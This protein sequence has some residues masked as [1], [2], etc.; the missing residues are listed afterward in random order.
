MKKLFYILIGLVL[1]PVALNA[2]GTLS[3]KQIYDNLT[4]NYYTKTA[5]D[6]KYATS[7]DVSGKADKTYVDANFATTAENALKQNISDMVDYYT[8]T[9]ADLLLSDKADTDSV[10]TKTAA[11]LL[12]AAKANSA[13]VYTTDEVN[14]L[15]NAKLDAATITNY[16]LKTETYNTGEIAL[17]LAA[18]ADA[19]DVYDTAAINLLLADKADTSS[20]TAVSDALAAHTGEVSG[21]HQ[22]SAIAIDSSGFTGNLKLAD[23]TVQKALA[24][25]DAL[26]GLPA[27]NAITKIYG[28]ADEVGSDTGAVWLVGT[29]GVTIDR[30]SNTFEV[31]IDSATKFNDYY[32]K[33]QTNA[34]IEAAIAAIPAPSVNQTVTVTAGEALTAGKVVS[35]INESGTMKA[36]NI[37]L[38]VSTSPN[39][40][41]SV[42]NSA[43][44]T[45]CKALA[46][47]STRFIVTFINASDRGKAIV[48]TVSGSTIAWGSISADFE[49]VATTALTSC[50]I[51][52]DKVLAAYRD[53][54]N[55]K[56]RCVVLSISTATI[57]VNSPADFT[58]EEPSNNAI[59]VLEND[60][61][62]ITYQ[63]ATKGR[64]KIITVSTTTPTPYPAAGTAGTEFNAAA[65]SY[66]SV[67]AL[68]ATE[69][70]V[71]YQDGGN[72]NFG[73][74]Q[75][76]SISGTTI[77]PGTEY[78]FVEANPTNYI[79]ICAMSS[80]T[81]VISYINGATTGYADCVLATNSSG[82][83]YSTVAST[84][85]TAYYTS[86]AKVNDTH[87]LL[88][89]SGH[90]AS[91]GN[92]YLGTIGSGTLALA[93]A[94]VFNSGAAAN[95]VS[96]C[97]L[98]LNKSAICY[99]DGG[100]SSHG[101]AVVNTWATSS[102]ASVAGLSSGAYSSGSDAVV[103]ISG[104]DTNQSGL[105]TGS[106][107]FLQSDFTLGTTPVSLTSSVYSNAATTREV[108]IGVAKSSTEIILGIDYK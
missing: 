4:T 2:Q 101:T 66:I 98:G 28:S 104:V 79:S 105:I 36:Y 34:A 59:D 100:N 42:F 60:K 22:G 74:S 85:K 63:A 30:T 71:A 84:S 20:V 13:D 29:N 11:D 87:F 72:S 64:T 40:A 93:T 77:T 57:T 47:D 18:K 54:N 88:G 19:A 89:I 14:I 106:P 50:K 73:T 90:T 43:A 24:T 41:E 94:S 95:Y 107:Y 3:L 62:I 8:K 78:V 17:L 83:T 99:S 32:N 55:S 21:A 16:Y 27:T 91:V 108:K 53:G 75:I 58:T 23:D 51:G 44:T 102:Y 80:S 37:P 38:T 56:G 97:Y 103:L 12:F 1:I 26:S 6:G 9:A 68:S 35:L 65:T 96:V 61:A 31:N 49:A 45:S 52:T 10:Y 86:V 48:G 81:A 46:L 67:S 25:L 82:L 5:S 69:A 70:I 39:G 7:A 15:L 33:A 76:L 92:S